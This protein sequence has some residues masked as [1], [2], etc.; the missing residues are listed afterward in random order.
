MKKRVLFFA[1]ASVVSLFFARSGLAKEITVLYSGETHAML[2]PCHCPIEPDGGVAR[3]AKLIRDL[4]NANPNNTLVLDSGA[5]FA[6]GLMDEYT[7]NTQLDMQRS[8]INLEAME[9][10][11]YDAAAIGDDEFNFGREFLEKNIPRSAPALLSCNIP[12]SKF[13]PYIIKDLS[14]TRVGI[15][16]ITGLVAAKKADGLKLTEPQ[17]ALNNTLTR[18]KAEGVAIIVVLSHQ[19]E[20][21]D[22]DL[23][24]AVKGIDV[25]I[26]A[27]SRKKEEAF[28]KSGST[29]ILRPSWQGRK[30][31]VLSLDVADNK[32]IDY[33]V[34]EVRLSDKIGNDPKVLEILPG[35][36]ADADCR[37]VGALGTC[38]NPG[39][40]GAQ[41][42]FTAPNKVNLT[43][44]APRPCSVCDTEKKVDWLKTQIPGLSASNIYYPSPKAGQLIKEMGL[45]SLPAYILGREIEQEKAFAGLKDNLE[46][47]GGNYLFRPQWSGITLFLDR[48]REKGKLDLFISLYDRNAPGILE[49]VSGFNTAV[50]FLALEKD[51]KFEVQNGRAEFEDCLRAVC[52]KKYYPDYFQKYISCRAK[53][54]DSSWWQD[55]AE[56]LDAQK[57]KSCAQGQESRELLHENISLNRELDIRNG[58]TYLIEN[59]DVYSSRGV[60]DKEEIK[61]MFRK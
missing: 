15:I 38:L 56:G 34:K 52:I 1:L 32:I 16:G 25:L 19:G 10:V 51:T 12:G 18:L 47:K 26:T 30:L 53:N 54:T 42:S 13:T 55:C 9:L 11:G 3:R 6:G 49:A 20:G 61:R 58:P 57:I 7:Q 45:K 8:L 21:E 46:L 29:I 27:H 41:C 28:T 40:L 37:K 36:F 35:C 50:H 39:V 44:I 2:Y 48:K 14:G 60:P 43:V 5:F 59:Q 17:V 4:R 31:G 33:R 24:E 22:L 23:L